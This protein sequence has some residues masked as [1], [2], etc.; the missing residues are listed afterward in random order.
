VSSGYQGEE[1]DRTYHGATD[2]PT[3]V[4]PFIFRLLQAILAFVQ[5]DNLT[6][7]VF[8][9]GVC[10]VA[11]F[12]YRQRL[13]DSPIKFQKE[14]PLASINSCCASWNQRLSNKSTDG[15]VGV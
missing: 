6:D 5:T 8:G 9:V 2:N 1:G 12:P 10:L 13:Q 7:V 4:A 11:I 3:T 14:Y 15:V